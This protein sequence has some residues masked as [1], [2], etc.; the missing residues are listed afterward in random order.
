MHKLILAILVGT[1]APAHGMAGGAVKRLATPRSI[2][3]LS[4]PAR[5]FS[6]ASSD[7]QLK[8]MAAEL[9]KATERAE[10]AEKKVAGM[11]NPREMLWIFAFGGVI[12]LVEKETRP[13]R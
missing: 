5:T 11:L 2:T 3:L 12:G 4:Q 9:K 10:T 6:S 1:V 7:E 13:Y 8:K